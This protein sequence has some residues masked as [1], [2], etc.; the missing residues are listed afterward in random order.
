M[1]DERILGAVRFL[2]S[3]TR[4][5]VDTPLAVRATGIRKVIPPPATVVR[6]I[7][8]RWTRTRRGLLALRSVADLDGADPAARSTEPGSY[9]LDLAI[10]DPAGRYLPRRRTIRLPRDPLPA[11]ADETPP[12]LPSDLDPDQEEDTPGPLF[13]P[14]D[15]L[16]FPAPVVEVS[17]GWAALRATITGATADARLGGALVRVLR[18][19]PHGLTHLGNALSDERGEA[20]VAVT[21]IP[22]TTF[23]GGGHGPVLSPGAD[24]QLEI[25][26]DPSA[27]K[28]PDPLDLEKRRGVLLVRTVP[29]RLVPGRVLVQ[30]L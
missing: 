9:E 25:V 7:A 5:P 10:F 28:P 11:R 21:G 29:L 4:L 19:D 22:A 16:L 18:V 6:E 27:V 26:Y 15:V 13:Q 2:D 14:I 8:V 1:I 30:T 20:L 17:A 3:V 24:V 23:D 12:A